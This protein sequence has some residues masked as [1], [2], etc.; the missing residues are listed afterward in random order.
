ML[1]PY[2]GLSLTTAVIPL[3]GYTLLVLV[4]EHPGRLPLGAAGGAGRR[5]GHGPEPG[6]AGVHRRAAAGRALHRHRDP[7]GGGDDGGP[8]HRGL[9]HRPGR[10]RPAD[11]R[12]P[13]A[14]VLDADDGGRVAVHPAGAGASTWC[15]W[16][17]GRALTPWTRAGAATDGDPRWPPR[18]A[19]RSDIGLFEWLF[20]AETWTGHDGILSSAGRHRPAVRG[21]G[22]RGDG[23]GRPAGRR[24]WPTSGKGELAAPWFV[25][26]GRAI[27]TFAVAGL[28]VPIS[29]RWGYGFE[30]WP[31][32]IALTLLA[33]PPIFLTTYTAVKGVDPV[34]RRRRPGHGTRPQER[35]AQGGAGPRPGRHPHRCPRGRRAG[36]GHRA[37][38]GLPRRQRPRPLRPG[39]FGTE[40]RQLG[41][42]GCNPGGGAGPR[43]GLGVRG[44]RAAGHAARGTKARARQRSTIRGGP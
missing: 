6:P 13:A 29:L 42:R 14:H 38:P 31:I 25:N 7:G 26:V 16:L 41:A 20:D 21:G 35:T 44:P 10:P 37:A 30:P 27:P 36:R 19:C 15:I 4:T 3:V 17:V 43:D 8:G 24:S 12:R 18:P 34:R 11:P 22:R 40:Q 9:D 1:V 23:A 33:V 5:R 2:T 39:R 28:L 32:F